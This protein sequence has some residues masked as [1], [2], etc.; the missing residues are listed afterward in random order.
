MPPTVCWRAYLGT[1]YLL[2]SFEDCLKT[3][4]RSKGYG[5]AVLLPSLDKSERVSARLHIKSPSDAA[6]TWPRA[7]CSAWSSVST[8]RISGAPPV[9]TKSRRESLSVRKKRQSRLRSRLQDWPKHCPWARPRTPWK[10]RPARGMSCHLMKDRPS[11][12]STSCMVYKYL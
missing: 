7:A 1:T 9:M 2:C 3:D 5:L 12:F 10:S 11:Q 4:H 6:L 8:L